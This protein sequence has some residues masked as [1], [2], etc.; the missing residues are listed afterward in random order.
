[1]AGHY[2]QREAV[3]EAKRSQERMAEEPVCT[4]CGNPLSAHR[5]RA[6]GA[7]SPNQL[8]TQSR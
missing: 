4:N 3:Y 5:K 7:Q 8:E 1:M 6:L 2:D